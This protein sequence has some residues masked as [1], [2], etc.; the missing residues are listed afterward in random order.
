MLLKYIGLSTTTGDLH[1]TV[2][3][4]STFCPMTDSRRS[5]CLEFAGTF[6]VVV[7]VCFE[8]S[9]AVMKKQMSASTAVLFGFAMHRYVWKPSRVQPSANSHLYA[10]YSAPIELCPPFQRGP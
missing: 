7:F 9:T 5:V 1:V 8:P 10:A 4:T 6:S 3:D 2:S